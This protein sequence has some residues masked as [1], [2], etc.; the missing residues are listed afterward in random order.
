MEGPGWVF[1]KT[2]TMHLFMYKTNVLIGGTYAKLPVN[3]RGILFV[4]TNDKYSALWSISAKRF[5]A[6][7]N[8]NP[9][10]YKHHFDNMKINCIDFSKG[11]KNEELPEI[12]TKKK[13]SPKVFELKLENGKPKLLPIARTLYHLSLLERADLNEA[14]LG[15][16]RDQKVDLVNQCISLVDQLEALQQ[17]VLSFQRKLEVSIGPLQLSKDKAHQRRLKFDQQS[18]P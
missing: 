1:D 18:S 12:E 5:L 15:S 7:T 8:E 14:G 4:K 13:C 10:K 9:A 16:Y 11:L 3:G 6:K 17:E 2:L